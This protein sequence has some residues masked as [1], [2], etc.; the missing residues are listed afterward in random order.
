MLRDVEVDD[1]L[2]WEVRAA[3]QATATGCALHMHLQHRRREGWSVER[4]GDP[5]KIEW[6]LYSVNKTPLDTK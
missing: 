6:S 5:P 3:F 2:Q 4:I 1:E